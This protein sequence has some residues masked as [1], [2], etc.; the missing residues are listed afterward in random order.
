MRLKHVIRRLLQT[1]MFTAITLLTLAVGIGANSAIFAVVE[2]VLLK[3]LPYYHPEQLVD[4]NHTAPGVGMRDAGSAPFLNYAYKDE[5]RVFQAV[6]LWRSDTDSV[7]GIG[8]PEEVP[9]LDVTEGILPILGAQPVYVRLFTEQDTLPS[10]ADTVILMYGY[11]QSKFG[12][13]ASAVGRRMIV[14]GKAREII[15]VLPKS[16]QF[17]DR[18]PSIV[19][20]LRFDRQKTYLGNFSYQ[21]IGR[22]KPGV[23][24]EQANADAARIVPIALHKFPAFPGYSEKMFE[25]AKLGPNLRLLKQSVLGDIGG[26]LWVLMGTVGMVLLIACANVANLM[27]VRAQGREHELAI[28]SALGAGWKQIVRELLSE[29]MA[30]GLI[31][32]V[33]AIGLAMAGLRLL[34]S[35]APSNLPRLDQISMDLPTIAFT[36]AIS[37]FAGFLFGL[38]PAIKYAGRKLSLTLRAGGRSM[39]QSRER[40]RARNTLVVVQVA[41]ALVLLIS[42]G[43]MIRT[44]VALRHVVPGFANPAELQ[45]VGLYIPESYAKE[46]V[47]VI[48]M[49][50]N[51]LDK[52]AA[53]PGVSSVGYTSIVPMT[54][55]GWHDPVFAEGHDYVEGTIPPLRSYKFISPGLLKTMGNTLIAGREFTWA[56]VYEKRPI[57]MVSENLARELWGSPQAALGKQIRENLKATWREVVGVVSDERDDGV[58]QKAPTIAFWLPMMDHFEGDESF[59]QRGFSLVIRSSRAGTHS[60]VEEVGRAVWSVNANLPLANVRT[61][62]EIYSKSLARTSFALVMLAIAGAMALLLGLAGIY[63]VISYS[64]S[65]RTREIG[66]RMALGAR[67]QEVTGMFVRNGAA[68]AGIGIAFGLGV[69]FLLMRLMSSLLF[70]VKPVDPL[71]YIGVSLGLAGA[72]AL[73]S[74]VPALRATTIDPVDA[75]RAE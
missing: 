69:A 13:D 54:G 20:P 38:L 56:D 9:S 19:F 71:T 52:I 30:L 59:V 10:S 31:G 40:H 55:L 68:L 64:V 32:G 72:A 39:S 29:S 26:V 8:Q 75:L 62:S 48:R 6:G 7:T 15:A 46:P 60:F 17:L 65:Q 14:N 57:S 51:I 41:L 50:Q 35:L 33:I 1:P 49:Q 2:G 47:N 36:L 37:L 25:D 66:I 21:G 34:V 42:S 12:G 3:P 74:Y 45:I 18:K 27:L 4:L 70:D 5:S 44:F 23:S 67:N 24:L 58:N 11:W 22:L 16:F 63:G 43:L 28:R 61:M 53:I 73:A